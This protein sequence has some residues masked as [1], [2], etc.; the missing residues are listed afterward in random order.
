M[1]RETSG[2]NWLRS[3]LMGQRKKKRR[4]SRPSPRPEPRQRIVESH[5]ELTRP[6]LVRESETSAERPK[7]WK[8][9][10]PTALSVLAIALSLIFFF[11]TLSND[12]RLSALE[13]P[14]LTIVGVPSSVSVSG[15]TAAGPV[16]QEDIVWQIANVGRQD[17]TLVRAEMSLNSS[18]DRWVC[19]FDEPIL[20][21]AGG[22]SMVE[23]EFDAELDGAP[24]SALLVQADESKHSVQVSEGAAVRPEEMIRYLTEDLA[25]RGICSRE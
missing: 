19:W 20:V 2:A 1:L 8:F 21:A 3:R 18:D 7:R 22:L 15:Q 12:N 10:L 5:D 4:R 13:G 9:W 6:F 17:S 23:L 16:G 24:V 11:A 25:G 14:Q